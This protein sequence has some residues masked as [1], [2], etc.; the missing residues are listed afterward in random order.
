[1]T[2]AAHAPARARTLRHPSV[3]TRLARIVVLAVIIGIGFNH[4][5][6]SV[7]DWHLSDMNA[8][9]DAAMR[10]RVG[11]ELCPPASDVTASD[12]YRY[13]PWFAWLWVPLTSLPRGLVNVAWSL[14]LVGASV[15]AI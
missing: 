14:I 11:G 12:V 5:W 8:Y 3:A 10:L 6:W 9:W 7:T 4:V 1:M 15:A 2:E 13:S